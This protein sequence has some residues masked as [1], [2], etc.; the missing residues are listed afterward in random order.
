MQPILDECSHIDFQ[1]VIFYFTL[2]SRFIVN[3]A[4]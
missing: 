4:L 1:I 3:A 2:C